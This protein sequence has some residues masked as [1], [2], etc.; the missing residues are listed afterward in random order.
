MEQLIVR[1]GSNEN[2]VIHW[3][4]CSPNEDDVIAS[5]ELAGVEDL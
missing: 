2:D 5:G 4:V 3:I 1:L